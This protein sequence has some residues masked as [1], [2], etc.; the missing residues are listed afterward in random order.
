[1]RR[2]SDLFQ[3]CLFERR[4]LRA[5]SLLILL[6]TALPAFG[7]ALSVQ[8]E[9]IART[10]ITPVPGGVGAIYGFGGYPAIDNSGNVV[11]TANGGPDNNGGSFQSGIYTFIGGAPGGGRY[12]HPDS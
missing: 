10:D 5:L 9:S 6:V 1:M 8:Y 7:A 11:F 12:A 4:P 2:I 3:N